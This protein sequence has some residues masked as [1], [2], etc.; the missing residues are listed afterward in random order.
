MCVQS[1]ARLLHVNFQI[2]ALGNT[3]MACPFNADKYPE[4]LTTQMTIYY[5]HHSLKQII[6]QSFNS[7]T[8]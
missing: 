8:I 5:G 6:N 2:Y 1:G 7:Y 4:Q 3:L